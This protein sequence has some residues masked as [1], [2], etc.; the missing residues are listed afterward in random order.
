ME[1]SKLDCDCFNLTKQS[2]S[3]S[4]SICMYVCMDGWMNGWMDAYQ[5]HLSSREGGEFSINNCILVNLWVQRSGL[6]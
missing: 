6:A 4:T 2:S 5:P 3:P 1:L